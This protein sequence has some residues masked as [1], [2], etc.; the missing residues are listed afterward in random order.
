VASTI[1]K[2]FKGAYIINVH[3]QIVASE[4]LKHVPKCCVKSYR[5][6]SEG[7]CQH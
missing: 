1:K 2:G 4:K 6:K 5:P 3:D 7:K